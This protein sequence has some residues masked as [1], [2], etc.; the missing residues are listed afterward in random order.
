MSP[1][2]WSVT[3]AAVAVPLIAAALGAGC[4]EPTPPRPG[5]LNVEMTT[6]QTGLRALLLTIAGPVDDL[7]L[8]LGASFRAFSAPLGTDTTRVAIVSAAAS[9][10]ESGALLVLNVPDVNAAA[11]YR[12]TVDEAANASYA[13]INTGFV[14]ISVT[15]P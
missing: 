7:S 11:S 14:L 9:P 1:K 12:I 2:R 10:L 13:L 6:T 5:L 4:D 3:R 8:P 15:S